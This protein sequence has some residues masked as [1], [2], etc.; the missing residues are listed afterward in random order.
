MSLCIAMIVTSSEGFVPV[1]NFEAEYLFH[2]Q[3]S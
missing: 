1:K 2:L 3:R